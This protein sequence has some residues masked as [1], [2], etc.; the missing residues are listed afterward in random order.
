MGV[1]GRGRSAGRTRAY[2]AAIHRDD[3]ALKFGGTRHILTE[4]EER[5][6]GPLHEQQGT[7]TVH[8]FGGYNLTFSSTL[9]RFRHAAPVFFTSNFITIDDHTVHTLF[10]RV[11]G[12]RRKP[13]QEN[14]PLTTDINSLSIMFGFFNDSDSRLP[15]IDG[16]DDT[17]YGIPQLYP[18]K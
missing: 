5:T 4:G 11:I 13:R 16:H 9:G 10:N 15:F 2:S 7:I 14:I 1:G 17:R 18:H 6:G 8:E 3:P 12:V